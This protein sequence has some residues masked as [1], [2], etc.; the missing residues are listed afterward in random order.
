MRVRTTLASGLGAVLVAGLAGATPALAAAPANDS[1]GGAVLISSL[2]FSATVDVT[3]A[4]TDTDD[5]SLNAQCGAPVT[6]HSVWYTFTPGTGVEGIV[7]DI[8]SSD[9]SAGAI[10]AEPDGNGGWL[11]DACGPGATGAPVT[12]G[13]EY[14]ILAF[15]DTAGAPAHTLQISVDTATVPAVDVTVSP[16]G[17]VDRNGN[18]T[19]TGTYTCSGGDF[20][21]LSSSLKQSVG[22][23]AILGDGY[24]DGACDGASHA[25]SATVVPYNGKFAGGKA[26][27]FTY[28]FSCGVISCVDTYKEQPVKLTK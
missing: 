12:E 15:S 4:T 17:K 25:W 21:S 23:F 5:A 3:D 27:S 28:A 11:V 6:E 22:R 10:I 24:Y 2:P 20:F 9:F 19:L 26:A 16:K 14:R 7:V 8:S 1:A 18:A 13:V